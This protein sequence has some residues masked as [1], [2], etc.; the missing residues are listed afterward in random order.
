[1]VRLQLGHASSSVRGYIRS[2]R[3]KYLKRK[4]A[5]A[6]P[7]VY[8]VLGMIQHGDGV[9]PAAEFYQRLTSA[10]KRT[11]DSHALLRH[12]VTRVVAR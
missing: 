10:Q 3:P 11:V 8:P 9:E 4:V 7:R 6:R 1:M 12:I 5:S 2:V